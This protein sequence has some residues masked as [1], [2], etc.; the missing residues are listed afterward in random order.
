MATQFIQ[1]VSSLTAIRNLP[2]GAGIGFY[3]GRFYGNANG[4][5]AP[6]G[7]PW[8]GDVQLVDADN[9]SDTDT[10]LP[11]AT[12]QAA[13]TAASAGDTIAVRPRSISAGATDPV[14]YAETVIVPA[15][16]SGLRIIGDAN[17]LAQGA[18]P[19]IKIGSGSTA[20]ITLRSPGCL[21]AGLGINGSGSTG[22]GI[23]IDDDGSTKTAFGTVITGCHLKN[24]KAHAT[25]GTKGGAVYWPAVGGGWQVRIEGN[26]F[27]GNVASIVLVG[28]SNDR[29]KD[30]VIAG[31]AFGA[32]AATAVDAY[33]YGAGGSGFNDVVVS[34]NT[35]DTVLPNN[36]SGTIH[37]YMD[38]TGVA[39]GLV[40][41]NFFAS[42][43]GTFGATGNAGKVPTTVILAG[44]YIESGLLART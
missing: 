35:F 1:K 14:D 36:T 12:I 43:S 11:Y 23:L 44:N 29:P 42:A 20:M 27:Y 6:L 16:K 38:L 37:R 19:Q 34:G 30:V 3:N 7:G 17:G 10:R 2:T 25:D 31:N 5:V 33:I 9:G 26:R 40:A 21:I 28:T 32:D 4:T 13:V 39:S 41:H 8:F 18:E 22:G 15:G 24:C